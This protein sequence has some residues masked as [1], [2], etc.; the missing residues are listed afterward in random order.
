M[1]VP[2]RVADG[3]TGVAVEGLNVLVALGLKLPVAG[4]VGVVKDGV[5]V[6]EPDAVGGAGVALVEGTAVGVCSPTVAV[7]EDIEVLVDVGGEVGEVSAG[8]CVAVVSVTVPV[9]TPV[10]V[11]VDVGVLVAAALG[12]AAAEPARVGEL[13]G[14]AVAVP[15]ALTLLVGLE[16]GTGDDVGVGVPP[17]SAATMSALLTTPSP[18]RSHPA[19]SSNTAATTLSMRCSGRSAS[20]SALVPLAPQEAGAEPTISAYALARTM[21]RSHVGYPTDSYPAPAAE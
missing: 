18:F 8:V 3:P 2:L 21:R 9:G 17:R 12:V 11:A 7:S 16:V 13:D 6:A 1:I 15:D 20:H 4:G 5:R 10:L 14:V 19:P